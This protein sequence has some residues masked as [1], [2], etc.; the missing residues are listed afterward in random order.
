MIKIDE[1][2]LKLC[3]MQAKV[4]EISLSKEECSSLIFMRRFMNS[5]VAQAIE[6]ILEARG[7]RLLRG[8]IKRESRK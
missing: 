4:F 1:M 5:Q 6:R 2:G 3:R 7:V 8:I